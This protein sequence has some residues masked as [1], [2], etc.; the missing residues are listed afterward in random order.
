MVLN[1]EMTRRRVLAWLAKF[2]TVGAGGV[3]LSFLGVGCGSAASAFG[4]VVSAGPLAE[5]LSQIAEDREPFYVPQARAYVNPFPPAALPAARLI[6]AY[7]EVLPSYEAGVVALYQRCTHLGCRVP[8]CQSSQWFEC[9]C[10]GSQYNRVGEQ[11][12]GPA[13][14]GLD[15]FAVTVNGGDLRIDTRKVITGPPIGTNTT[16]QQADGPHCNE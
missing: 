8:W 6:P 7:A 10:H 12:H 1:M 3:V 9:P 13:P 16:G 4:G 14:R 11:K 5:A 2:G 15:R